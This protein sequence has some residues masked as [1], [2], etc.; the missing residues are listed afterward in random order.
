MYMDLCNVNICG[1][2]YSEKLNKK[3][4]NC[5]HSTAQTNLRLFTFFLAFVVYGCLCECEP[6]CFGYVKFC[7]PLISTGSE[8]L[9]ATR[10]SR[11]IY[12]I[13]ITL[14]VIIISHYVRSNRMPRNRLGYTCG[15]GK[16]GRA[17]HYN[18]AQHDSSED[19]DVGICHL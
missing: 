13:I 10:R 12:E 19:E 6:C 8:M 14:E 18:K 2:K 17:H 16:I 5:Y 3:H 9:L 15:R 7:Y 11:A 4:L 1:I